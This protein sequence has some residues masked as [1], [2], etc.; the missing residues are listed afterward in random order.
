M[1]IKFEKNEIVIRIPV[2]KGAHYPLS[3][4]GKTRLVATT[5]SFKDVDGSPVDK[6]RVSVNVICGLGE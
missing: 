2:A 6:L 3:K 1:N 4:S 5:G